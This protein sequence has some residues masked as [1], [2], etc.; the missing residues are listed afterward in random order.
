MESNK[1]TMRIISG[2]HKGKLVKFLKTSITRPLKDS[3]RESV[4]NILEHSNKIPIRIN[5]SNILDLYS[6]IG[7]FGLEALSRGARE[8]TFVEQNNEAIKILNSNLI[9]LSLINKALVINNKIENAFKSLG[10]KKFN[11]IFFDPPFSDSN[12][13]ENLKLLKKFKLYSDNHIIIIHREKNAE[14]NLDK[15]INFNEIKQYGRSK[16]IFADRI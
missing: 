10:K 2:I 14:D 5:N 15:I 8:V 16:I 6:G 13:I 7:S 1:K 3:V 11:I 9:D 12:F 4:F